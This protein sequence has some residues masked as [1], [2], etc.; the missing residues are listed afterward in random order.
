[1]LKRWDSA[2]YD[3]DLMLKILHVILAALEVDERFQK[4]RGRKPKRLPSFYIKA[5]VL[6]EV[7]KCSLRYSESLARRFLKVRIP[8]STLNYWEIKH[9]GLI[10]R[11]LNTLLE[12]IDY[13][14]EIL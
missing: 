13:F 3:V 1:M 2:I 12:Q 14:Y 10:I 6:K 4:R 7:F 5:I 8:K 9:S 11:A